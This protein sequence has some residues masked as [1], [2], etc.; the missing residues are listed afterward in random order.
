MKCMALCSV[1]DRWCPCDDLH[2]YDTLDI[3]CFVC[4][5]INSVT[6][7]QPELCYSCCASQPPAEQAIQFG[8]QVS[9]QTVAAPVMRR[10]W[11]PTDER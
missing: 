5:V 6:V 11:R 10:K 3:V 4:A 7:K 2:C 9:D 1:N 8:G